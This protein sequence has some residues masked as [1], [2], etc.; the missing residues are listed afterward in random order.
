MTHEET[1]LSKIKAVLEGRIDADV[2]SYKIGTREITKI[3]IKELIELKEIYQ[4]KV[5]QDKAAAD[6]AA[7]LGNPNTIKVRF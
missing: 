5:N 7:G 6:V 3:P 2:E 1:M 4:A